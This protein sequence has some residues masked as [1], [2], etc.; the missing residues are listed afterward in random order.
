MRRAWV[1]KFKANLFKEALH[2][3]EGGREEQKTERAS[4]NP[5]SIA[6]IFA[7]EQIST[8]RS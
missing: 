5:P 6:V 8:Q 2:R 4:Y 3:K 1:H 7:E